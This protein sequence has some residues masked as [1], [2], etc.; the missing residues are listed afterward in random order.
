[1]PDFE[2]KP[3]PSSRRMSEQQKREVAK[4]VYRALRSASRGF[5]PYGPAL[6][7]A[8]IVERAGLFNVDEALTAVYWMR[9][10]GVKVVVAPGE[11]PG[12]PAAV[13]LVEALPEAFEVATFPSGLEP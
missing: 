8:Q 3:P 10:K 2:I 4:P 1:M 11:T 5:D 13:M 7:W 9:S 6:T 12:E